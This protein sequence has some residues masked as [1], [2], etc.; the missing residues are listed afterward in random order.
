MKKAKHS[1][2]A[3]HFLALLRLVHPSL[4][5]PLNHGLQALDVVCDIHPQR[6]VQLGQHEVVRNLHMCQG[7]VEQ[8][9]DPD[10]LTDPAEDRNAI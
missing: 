5:F 6:L 3:Q 7:N 1:L 8:T 10:C 9:K 2:L 4:V